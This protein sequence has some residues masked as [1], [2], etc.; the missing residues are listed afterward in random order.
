M[1]SKREVVGLCL[2]CRHVRV[3][4]SQRGGVFYLC[5]LAETDPEFPKYPRLPVKECSG[6]ERGD[7]VAE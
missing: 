3:V 4:E 5:R 7:S 6:Y 2:A 1:K